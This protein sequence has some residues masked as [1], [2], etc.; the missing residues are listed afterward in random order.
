MKKMISITLLIILGIMLSG[1]KPAADEDVID[2]VILDGQDTVEINTEWVDAG[3]ELRYNDLVLKAIGIGTVNTSKIGMYE[4][5]YSYNY[6]GEA[7]GESRFVMVVDQIAPVV[8]LNIG[9]DTVTVG[10]T[11]EDSGANVTDNSEE[12]LSITVLGSVDTLTVGQYE[13]TYTAEDSSGNDSTTTR[14]VNVIN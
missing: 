1:C 8:T 12:E 7:Y 11:W 2:F 10:S 14:Y 3:A 4:I 13:I 5:A 6:S 9:V